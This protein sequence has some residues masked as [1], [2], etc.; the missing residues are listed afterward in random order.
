M[1]MPPYPVL[2][3]E[4]QCGQPALYKIAARWSD[5]LT[6]ELKTYGLTCERC[7]PAWFRRSQEKQQACRRAANEVLEPPG[8]YRL[9]KARHDMELERL[10]DLE[11]Q[12]GAIQAT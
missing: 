9:Q 10:V 11:A 1:P 7:L 12:L 3:Y 4:P 5:G 8:I 2:C 6:G